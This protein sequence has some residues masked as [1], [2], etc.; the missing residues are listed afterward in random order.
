MAKKGSSK[1]KGAVANMR[2]VGIIHSGSAGNPDHQDP[3]DKFMQG[4]A[5]AGFDNSNTTFFGPAYANND[6]SVLDQLAANMVSQNNVEVLVAAGGTRS[7]LAAQQASAGSQTK[8]VFTSVR[9]VGNYQNHVTGICALTSAL[10]PDRLELLCMLQHHGEIGVLTNSVRTDFNTEWAALQTKA[11]QLGVTLRPQDVPSTVPTNQ[12]TLALRTA[13]Q[14]FAATTPA[15]P[16]PRPTL[17]MADP[18]FNDCRRKVVN[19]ADQFDVPAMYQWKQFVNAGGLM[20]YG[21]RMQKAYR[22]AGTYVGIYLSTGRLPP[23]RK[24]APELI[25][26]LGTANDIGVTIPEDLLA[27]ADEAPAQL[28]KKSASRATKKKS[29]AKKARKKK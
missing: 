13:F 28:M 11:G 21:T 10:D 9:E 12:I 2:R 27:L 18:F 24:L 15:I 6:F 22:A 29:K 16:E 5:N 25:I 7:A 3:I 17:V 26:N 14:A 4:L 23:I 1:K 20:S 19:A 8:V